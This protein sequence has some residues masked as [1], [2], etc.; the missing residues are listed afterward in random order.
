MLAAATLFASASFA[1]SKQVGTWDR[2]D[3][4]Y[5]PSMERA[6]DTIAPFTFSLPCGGTFV[7]YQ[8]NNGGYVAGTN[9]YSDAEKGQYFPAINADVMGLLVA[10]GAKDDQGGNTDYMAHVYADNAGTRG[11]LSG[12]SNAVNISAIDT[13][14]GWTQYDFAVP[15][16]MTSGFWIGVDVDGTDT[17]GIIT[18]QD[19]C[20]PGAAYEQWSDG[21][22]VELF[23]ST[24]AWGLEVDHLMLV[25]VDN[26]VIPVGVEEKETTTL[27]PYFANGQLNVN[28]VKGDLVINAVE[29]VDFAGRTIDNLGNGN[30]SGGNQTWDVSGM[31]GGAYIVVMY[32]NHGRFAMKAHYAK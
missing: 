4:D 31:A 24:N 18:T 26:L 32:T 17:V 3:F 14:G 28:G 21:T 29:L 20:A 9:G 7:I 11:A 2:A 22:T 27:K 10:Y 5:T 25:I 16:V 8:S 6:I 19:P 23:S 13:A 15:Q 30:V 12:S 1:Q